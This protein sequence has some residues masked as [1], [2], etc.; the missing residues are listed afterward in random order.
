MRVRCLAVTLCSHVPQTGS[1]LSVAI[2]CH[3]SALINKFMCHR[4][5]L[6]QKICPKVLNNLE[7]EG[8]KQKN[9]FFLNTPI[10]CPLD[11]PVHQQ[12]P[13]HWLGS[14]DAALHP[15]PLKVMVEAYFGGNVGNLEIPTHPCPHNCVCSIMQQ[16]QAG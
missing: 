16:S 6:R 2:S 5:K 14:H 10:S 12:L 13:S 8:A 3:C 1:W 9:I 7:Y 11:C 4:D 15:S